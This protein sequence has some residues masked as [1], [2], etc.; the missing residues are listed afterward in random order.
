MKQVFIIAALVIYMLVIIL[1]VRGRSKMPVIKKVKDVQPGDLIYIE[2]Y[3]F[4]NKIGQVQ[5]I[6]NTPETKSILIEVRWKNCI[7]LEIS[8]FEQ[9]IFYYDAPELKNF[10]VLNQPRINK[11]SKSLESLQE[12]LQKAIEE[13]NYEEAERL[14]Q[15][16][17]KRT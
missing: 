6:S 13:E 3:R 2:W 10:H 15:Q 17:K 7:E 4:K 8:E 12:Q 5:C 9:K 11:Q 1:L 16:I 14:K